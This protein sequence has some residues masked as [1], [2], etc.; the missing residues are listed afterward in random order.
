[1]K[2]HALVVLGATLCLALMAFP[3]LAQDAVPDHNISEFELGEH[4]SGPEVD[5]SKQKGKVVAIE[6]WGTR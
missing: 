1:M 2:T 4:L 6:Y 5:L 3:A